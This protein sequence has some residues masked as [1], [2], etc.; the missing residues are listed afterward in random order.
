M[1]KEHVKVLLDKKL[2]SNLDATELTELID[3]YGI[4]PDFAATL[5]TPASTTEGV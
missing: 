1:T 2:I 3:K 4:D 5:K